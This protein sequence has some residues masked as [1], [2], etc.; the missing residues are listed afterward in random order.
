MFDPIQEKRNQKWTRQELDSFFKGPGKIV[1]EV[2]Q[3]NPTLYAEYR[4]AYEQMGGIGKSLAPNPAPY[5]NVENYESPTTRRFTDQEIELRGRYSEA[6]C[7][8]FISSSKEA[9]ELFENNRDEFEQRRLAAV[10]YGLVTPRVVPYT[11][12]PKPVV[13]PGFM[14]LSEDMARTAHL[15]AG[16]KVTIAQFCDLITQGIERRAQEQ[17]DKQAREA[18]SD[19]AE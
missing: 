7:K 16:T 9:T 11:P 5:V 12:Q 18:K 6:E 4:R 19:N 2:K 14:T 3:N 10:S 8:R 1:Q 13:E 17:A 15:P